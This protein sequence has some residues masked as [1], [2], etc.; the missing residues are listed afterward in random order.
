MR[1]DKDRHH[2][3]GAAVDNGRQGAGRDTHAGVEHAG[4]QRG[5]HAHRPQRRGDHV[6]GSHG[7][8]DAR[9]FA[10]T[11]DVGGLGQAGGGLDVGQAAL[12]DA[13]QDQFR[14]RPVHLEV[15]DGAAE[16]ALEGGDQDGADNR[17]QAGRQQQPAEI[18]Q[19]RIGRDLVID[20]G[21][22][23]LGKERTEEG[24]RGA[25]D[26]HQDAEQGQRHRDTPR[27]DAGDAYRIGEGTD[28]MDDKCQG[29]NQQQLLVHH[30]LA[31]WKMLF[32][33]AMKLHIF[34]LQIN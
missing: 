2:D 24:V 28:N 12:E 34:Q 9:V 15:F 26:Q 11:S 32:H 10:Q 3:G 25:R 19:Q 7:N 8:G 22:D 1:I 13:V 14:Y 5:K 33:A 30:F 6:H 31:M 16:D 27:A 4:V 23:S 17:G 20:T 18:D 21:F 29:A